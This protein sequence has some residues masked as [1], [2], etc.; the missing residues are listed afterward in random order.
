MAK[1]SIKISSDLATGL[2]QLT[3]KN[4]KI[5]QKF[6]IGESL[7]YSLVNLYKIHI[8]NIHINIHMYSYPQSDHAFGTPVISAA[9]FTAV[10]PITLNRRDFPRRSPRRVHIRSKSTKRRHPFARSCMKNMAMIMSTLEADDCEAKPTFFLLFP[11]FGW[12]WCSP[13]F[14]WFWWDVSWNIWSFTDGSPWPLETVP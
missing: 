13:P 3:K 5:F 10:G 6:E 7:Y 9:N 14:F 2:T 11:F 4:T 1:F 8:H 12:C